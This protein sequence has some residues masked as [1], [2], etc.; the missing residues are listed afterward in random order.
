MASERGGQFFEPRLKKND[1]VVAENHLSA[2]AVPETLIDR[3]TESQVLMREVN[4]E[5]KI[6]ARF[7][8]SLS[9][10][11]VPGSIIHHEKFDGRHSRQMLSATP[12][13]LNDQVHIVNSRDDD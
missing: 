12:D 9:Q 10:L 5:V 7:C 8:Q 11:W 6:L 2:L 13:A 4:F 3:G 1:V